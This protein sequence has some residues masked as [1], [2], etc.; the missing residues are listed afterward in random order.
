L[1]NDSS[2]WKKIFLDDDSG[3][4]AASEPSIF[5]KVF[6]DPAPKQPVRV[7]PSSSSKPRP[8]C[9]FWGMD[10]VPIIAASR[11]LLI[12]GSPGS[13]KT[14][15]IELFLQSI[16]HR[17]R[18]PAPG[19]QPERLIIL[20]VKGTFYS[21]LTAQGIPPEDIQLLDPFDQRSIPWDLCRDIT[22]DAAAQHL[23]ALLVPAE[24]EGQGKFF[25]DASQAIV[26]AV[27]IS[28]NTLRP[29]NWTLRDLV[30][31]LSSEEL[32][33]QLIA[34]VPR[35]AAR[36]KSFLNNERYFPD[37]LTTIATGIQ[38]F[39]TVAGLWQNSPKAG[40]GFSVTDWFSNNPA[41]KKHGVLLLGH[42][43]K[44]IDSITPLNAL[45]LR[46]ISDELQ[47]MPDVDQPHTW[48]VLDEFRWMKQV[49]CMAELLGVGR[50]KGASILLGL[51]DI[52]GMRTTYGPDRAEEILGLCENKTFLNI[53]N[54]ATAEWASQYF[55]QR[56]ATETKVSRTYSKENSTTYSEDIVTR[57]VY[58]PGEFLDMAKPINQPG[59]RF[60]G[61]HDIPSIGGAFSTDEEAKAIFAMNR[62]PSKDHQRAFPNRIDREDRDQN[63]TPWTAE[64]SL[65]FL[66]PTPEPQPVAGSA[67]SG[68]PQ[69]KN[70]YQ[71]F[72]HKKLRKEP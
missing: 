9:F 17:F 49:E 50:S 15:S 44:Y 58:L 13:G 39:E 35:A 36:V 37:F 66:G 8:D 22:T 3:P 38:A 7:S 21:F 40:Q 29:K 46:V 4:A 65:A 56:E 42:R 11:H 57:P 27:I 62:K 16:A 12:I 53:G 25:W 2:I 70:P 71:E 48:I 59:W 10:D 20:D 72:L 47:S 5:E 60:E 6:M 64:E 19:A 63:L 67:D 41:R 1:S 32:L 33:R 43:P 24:K 18:E 45:L 28:L 51:Q 23:A 34:R 30:N 31:V 68:S 54:P 52:S 14:L 61:I 26:R 69:S 55:A